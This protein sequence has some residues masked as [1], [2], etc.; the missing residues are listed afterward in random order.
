MKLFGNS[1]K[2][3][4]KDKSNKNV[5]YL[6]I[7]EAILAHYNT[8]NNDYQHDLRVLHIFISDKSFR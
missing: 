4:S 8:V 3:T 6:E 7:I 1:E 5:S 2:Q